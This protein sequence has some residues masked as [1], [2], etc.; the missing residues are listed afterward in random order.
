MLTYAVLPDPCPDEPAEPLP[1][2]LTVSSGEALRPMPAGVE[3]AHVAAHAVRH[4]ADLAHRDPAVRTHA[5]HDPAL[6]SAVVRA[7][8]Q[9]HH[10]PARAS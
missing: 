3:H 5:R 8:R 9:A 6:W 4:L 10:E 7:A 2:P 1:E